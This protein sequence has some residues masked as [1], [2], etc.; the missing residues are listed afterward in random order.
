MIFNKKLLR[1]LSKLFLDNK[2]VSVFVKRIYSQSILLIL[3]DNWAICVF[4]DGD[5]NSN[6]NY[7]QDI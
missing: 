4:I 1:I 6:K 7:S 5:F 3:I 2:Y